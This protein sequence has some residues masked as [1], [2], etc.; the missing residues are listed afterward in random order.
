[1]WVVAGLTCAS[2]LVVAFRMTETWYPRS[3]R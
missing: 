2:G 3:A 1:M